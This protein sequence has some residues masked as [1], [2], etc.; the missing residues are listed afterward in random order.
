MQLTI[1]REALHVALAQTA[2][3]VERR[4]TIPILTNV[5]LEAEGDTLTLTATDLDIEARVKA[6][7]I[8]AQPGATTVPAGLFSGLMA[9]MPSGP[10]SLVTDAGSQL[11]VQAGR[12]KASLNALPATDFPRLQAEAF[13]H[14][15]SLPADVLVDAIDAVAFA[16]STEEVRYYLNGIYMHVVD[17]QLVAVATDGHR[18]SRWR[19]AAPEGAEGMPGIIVPRK[20]VTEFAK[21]AAEGRKAGH[22]SLTLALSDA[23]IR[24]EIGPTL[25][26][27]KLIDGNYPDY[28][29]VIPKDF[30]SEATLDKAEA[31]AAIDRVATVNNERGRAIK[32]TLGGG[33]MRLDVTNPDAGSASEEMPLDGGPDTPLE[34][35]FNGRYLADVLA[36]LASET[37]TLRLPADGGSP[38]TFLPTT[39]PASGADRLVVLMPMRI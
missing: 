10:V 30:A 38:T 4:N 19:R 32:L 9:K 34:I 12:A 5:L 24:M 22:A 25:L 37:I 35:G 13:S 27:S 8:I 7:A 15:F 6:P 33:T 36:A 11:F 18:L 2:R 23:K 31:S 26:T 20:A 29:R 21:V 14:T 39:Q 17:G 1:E 16:I 28:I 3:V